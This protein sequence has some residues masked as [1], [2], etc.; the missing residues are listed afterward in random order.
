MA[1]DKVYFVSD[2][3]FGS[4]VFEHPKVTEKRFVRWLDT[5]REEAKVLYL[6]GDIFDFW[7][8]YKKV[9]PR[10]FTRFLGK[11]AEMHDQGTEIHFFTGNHDIW[12]FDYFQE[13][14]GAIVHTKPLTVAI[15]GKNFYLAHGDGLGDD[16]H[17]FKLIRSIFHNRFCQ[18]LF[19]GIPSRW[20]I[21]FA[22]SWSKQ[23]RQKGLASPAPYFGEDKEH[24]VLYA[25]AYIKEHPDI[26][27]LIFGHR[28]ILLDLM[29]NRKSRMMIIGDW[30]QYFSYAVFDG[31]ELNLEQYTAPYDL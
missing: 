29:L 2:M 15:D 6:L 8:E 14:V 20:G 31:K 26:D 18:V 13:E 16:S 3:H 30:M 1:K 24:L 25:K 7:F 17:S 19:A 4:T 21:G 28:H 12:M 9:V 5:I 10:G 23:S 22:H 27:Y 11:I